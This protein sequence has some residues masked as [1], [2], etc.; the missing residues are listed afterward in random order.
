[1]VVTGGR[2]GKGPATAG[3]R[4]THSGVR[5]L[6]RKLGMRAAWGGAAGVGRARMPRL[7]GR[8]A[9]GAHAWARRARAQCAA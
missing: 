2:R 6:L 1:V 3:G 4:T 8:H 5:V 9:V 7:R